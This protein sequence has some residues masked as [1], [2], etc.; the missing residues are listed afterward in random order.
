MDFTYVETEPIG[1]LRLMSHKKLLKEAR[2]TSENLP[3]IIEEMK[4]RR[5]EE[6]DAIR[7]AY[8]NELE[9]ML[10]SGMPTDVL[11]KEFAAMENRVHEKIQSVNESYNEKMD[12]LKG[13]AVWWQNEQKK[14]SVRR[15][16]GGLKAAPE[17]K[18]EELS[19]YD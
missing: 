15:F 1:D 12:E 10:M 17:I 16:A 7:K 11:M 13:R 18:P 2:N 8:S 19:H 9:D 6:V 3:T 14:S 4:Q 5:D